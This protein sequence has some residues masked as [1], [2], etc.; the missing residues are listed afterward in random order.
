MTKR[1]TEDCGES[2]APSRYA[3]R[4]KNDAIIQPY[5][6]YELFYEITFEVLQKL[7]AYEDLGTPKELKEIIELQKPKE[8]VYAK[9]D[10]DGDVPLCPICNQIL[11]IFD[12]HCFKCDQRIDWSDW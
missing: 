5:K 2:F 12:E 1:I 10:K 8:P 6:T 7:G 9:E 3:L 4:S 11:D